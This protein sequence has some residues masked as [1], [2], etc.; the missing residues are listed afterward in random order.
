M[1]KYSAAL[2]KGDRKTAAR[3]LFRLAAALNGRSTTGEIATQAQI[4]RTAGKLLLAPV[5]GNKAIQTRA[6]YAQG[7]LAFVIWTLA[8]L[9]LIALARRNVSRLRLTSVFILVW[10][11][12]A[13]LTHVPMTRTHYWI[14]GACAAVFWGLHGMIAHQN[15]N[16]SKPSRQHPVSAWLLPV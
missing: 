7:G 3:Y 8:T 1:R 9:L 14:A 16:I 10:L 12:I 4:R 2:D 15:P 6:I 13:W 11:G 5:N